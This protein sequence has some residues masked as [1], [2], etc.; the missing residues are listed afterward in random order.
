[1]EVPAFLSSPS[2]TLLLFGGK[3][4]VGKT[5][6][7][8]AAAL[9]LARDDPSRSVA[10]LSTDPAHS[11]LD[12]L[13]GD[14]ASDRIR[15][16]ELSA[17]EHLDAFK[18]RHGGHLREI[19]DRGTFL[20][21]EDI[22][23]FL[24]LSLPGMDEL[25]AF[26]DIARRAQTTRD[27]GR[28]LVV[29]TA[30]TGHTIRL[31]TMPELL[32]GWIGALDTLLAKHRYMKSL[33][34]RSYVPDELD[35]FLDDLNDA[36]AA[37]DALLRDPA[38]C[39]FVPV[40]TAEEMSLRETAS[41]LREL[42][43]LGIA[44]DEVV[45]NALVP[46]D[47][48]AACLGARESQENALRELPEPLAGRT[49]WAVPRAPEEVRGAERLGR[50]WSRASRLE[51]ALR[52]AGGTPPPTLPPR[53]ENP[54]PLPPAGVELL[55]FA[56]KGGVGKTTLA[57]ATAVRL[58]R[59]RPDRKV[60]L[61]SSDPAH[62]VGDCL[63]LPVG[64]RLTPVTR[65]LTALEIDARAELEALE[66]Q[67]REEL[68]ELFGSFL[69][70]LDVP[71]DRAV[72]EQLFELSP[73]GIDEV[74]ALSRVMDLLEERRFD[75]LVLDAAPTGHLLRLLELPE[76]VD[77]W[78]KAFFELLL[79]YRDVLRLPRASERLVALSRSLKRYRALLEDRARSALYAVSIPTEMALAETRDLVAACERMRVSVPVLFVNLVTPE[80]RCAFCE[81]R[82]REE[83]AVRERFEHTFPSRHVATVFR[84]SEPRGLDRLEGLGN[85]MY[86]P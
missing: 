40:T 61:F 86:R 44:A 58:A 24:A 15:V 45:V 9:A 13:A 75:V 33:F 69:G 48:C 57:C 59:E 68:D 63:D 38:R 41:L 53:V 37:A 84:Q 28:I 42:D 27:E 83:A 23:R 26:L 56:G 34:Q 67:Y 46:A 52:D 4:G 32:R 49:V 21:A 30:P 10:L 54:P 70:N 25:F 81:A 3:G 50:F 8:T 36:I 72:M 60:L 65:G 2:L 20:D 31:L 22:D 64:P 11:L 51:D 6:C 85:G 79:K 17:D 35:G 73:P 62:S 39:R 76:I 1:M 80:S 66:A 5:T 16:D 14:A 12:S 43:R 18:R 77:D 55:A 82:A 78:L 29:D 47:G 7:A 19:A 71:Y 74:M